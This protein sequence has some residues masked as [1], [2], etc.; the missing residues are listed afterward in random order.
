MLTG[1]LLSKHEDEQ[2]RTSN[3]LSEHKYE[4]QYARLLSFMAGEVSRAKGVEG[5]RAL[6]N[7]LGEG[8]QEI[9][10]LQHLLLQLRVI[11]EWL[12]MADEDVGD[13]MTVLEDEY[14]VVS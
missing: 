2:E 14:Q 7:L 4:G 11:H 8:E 5:I 13:G 9:V 10:G 3:F 1:Q 6:L 12:C